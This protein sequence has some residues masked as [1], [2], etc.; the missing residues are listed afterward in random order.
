LRAALGPG[1]FRAWTDN[2]S[3]TRRFS[4]GTVDVELSI[5]GTPGKGFVLG[6][7]VLVNKVFALS[8]KDDIID[9]DEPSLNG[10]GFSL[11]A[12][13]VFADF[14]PDPKGGLDFH[15]FLG[16]GTLVTSRP[17]NLSVDDPSGILLSGGVGYDWFVAEQLSLGVHARLT[18]GSLS[19]RET[20]TSTGVAVLVPALLVAGTY[21]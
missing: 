6:G 2:S 1:L 12:L 14:Y 9:G 4:G 19:V 17:G 11:N 18:G 21:H 8:S 13:G 10:V 20:T 7:S 16:A 3:D 15:A 5:G